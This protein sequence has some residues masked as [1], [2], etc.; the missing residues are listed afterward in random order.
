MPQKDDAVVQ[1]DAMQI[2][3]EEEEKP[4]TWSSRKI[5]LLVSLCLIYVASFGAVLMLSPFYSVVVSVAVIFDMIFK[6]M[7]FQFLCKNYSF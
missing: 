6:W 2:T 7:V 3:P 1:D 5:A 4:F